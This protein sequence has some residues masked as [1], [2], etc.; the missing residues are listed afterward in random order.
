MGLDREVKVDGSFMVLCRGFA[1]RLHAPEPGE[2]AHAIFLFA[3]RAVFRLNGAGMGDE[4]GS[5]RPISFEQAVFNAALR[6][7]SVPKALE[8]E[9]SADHS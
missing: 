1:P 6:A 9:A 2:R 8:P 5:L 3:G 4:S 7:N